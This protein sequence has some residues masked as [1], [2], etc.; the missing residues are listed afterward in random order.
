VGGGGE[1]L[2]TLRSEN[3]VTRISHKDPSNSQYKVDET[4]ETISSLNIKFTIIK[5]IDF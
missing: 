2:I 3:R 5:F 1:I 4:N